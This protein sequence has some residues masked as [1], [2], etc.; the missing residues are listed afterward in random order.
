[1]PAM[2]TKPALFLLLLMALAM[3][4]RAQ[5]SAPYRWVVD[6]LQHSAPTLQML[7]KQLQANEASAKAGSL[8]ADPELE[9]ALYTSQPDE[10]TRHDLRLT[11]RIE[12]PLYYVHRSRIRRLQADMA[13]SDYLVHR[14]EWVKEVYQVCSH[15]VYYNAYVKLYA[16]CAENTQKV[17]SIYEERLRQGDCSI[18]DYNRMQTELA[19]VEN[20]LHIA[21]VE[22]ALMADNLLMLAGGIGIEI[23]QD[24]FSPVTLPANFDEWLDSVRQQTP[25]LQLIAQQNSAA[26]ENLT[27][28]KLAW[29]PAVTIGYAAELTPGENYRGAT[30]GLALPLWQR[31]GT[32]REARLQQQAS[33]AALN[34]AQ[35][36]FKGSMKALYTKALA[37]QRALNNLDATLQRHNSE[38]LLFRA[39]KAGEITLEYYLQQVEFYHDTEIDI[40]EIQHELEQTVIELTTIG[41]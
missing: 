33:Q 21:Q 25:A 14:N 7:Q 13:Q 29:L 35:T 15:I 5:V 11:Q 4:A 1:M 30:A 9:V 18:L 24:T 6:S 2:S 16:H 8:F 32:V 31:H 38:E 19:A 3:E 40:L 10:G 23:Q 27:L 37:L 41:E 26:A 39:L 34:D 12:F 36:R 17:A 28:N 22:H 20:K